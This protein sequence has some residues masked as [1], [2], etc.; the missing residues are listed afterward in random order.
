MLVTISWMKKNYDKY[1][2]LY[3]NGVLPN[4]TFKISRSKKT[5]GY[6]SYNWNRLTCKIT[7]LSITMSNYYDS[8]EEVKLTTLLHEMIHIYDYATNPQHFICGGR[9]ARYDAHGW[10]FKKECRRLKEFGWDIEKYVTAE[11]QAV[12]SLTARSAALEKAKQDNALLCVVVGTNGYNWMVKTNDS[13]AAEVLNTISRCRWNLTL[14]SVKDINFYRFDNPALAARRSAGKSI[15][16]W[17]YSH[18]ALL[19]RLEFLKATEVH[20][21]NTRYYIDKIAA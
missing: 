15:R 12:S 16:G 3:F 1:N 18:E 7:P 6:A 11:E 20:V 13:H 5:W 9:K 17:K 14:G 4:I 19:H 10:W 2:D 8:P 21:K